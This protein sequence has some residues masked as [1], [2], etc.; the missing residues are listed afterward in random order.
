MYTVNSAYDQT[1]MEHSRP[2]ETAQL[3]SENVAE[4]AEQEL[5]LSQ[6]RGLLSHK[7][8]QSRWAISSVLSVH[9]DL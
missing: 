9:V 2:T 6:L 5:M 8:S 7:A 3:R 4:T 1:P